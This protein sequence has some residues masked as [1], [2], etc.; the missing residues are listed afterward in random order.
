MRD[1]GAWRSKRSFSRNS[2]SFRQ[3]QGTRLQT[4]WLGLELAWLKSS[5]PNVGVVVVL[6]TDEAETLIRSQANGG[7]ARVVTSSSETLRNLVSVSGN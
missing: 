6:R 4:D 5:H 1:G 2:P 3:T 7:V